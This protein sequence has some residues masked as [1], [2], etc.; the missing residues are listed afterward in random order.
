MSFHSANSDSFCWSF[1]V[2]D[3]N[4]AESN[5]IAK[6]ITD[7]YPDASV[8]M[9]HEPEQAL[10][11][12]E[13]KP[14]HAVVLDY[15][16][17]QID[18]LSLLATLVR[19]PAAPA[20]LMLTGHGDE[21]VAVA[22]IKRGAADYVAKKPDG[23]HLQMLQHRLK[24]M[25]A[26]QYAQD[27]PKA[28]SPFCDGVVGIGADGKVCFINAAAAQAMKINRSSHL[29]LPLV[30]FLS[31]IPS[32]VEQKFFQRV[33]GDLLLKKVPVV[34]RNDFFAN[35]ERVSDLNHQ[36]VTAMDDDLRNI[37]NDIEGVVPHALY[38]R[39]KGEEGVS[40]TVEVRLL[41]DLPL[42]KN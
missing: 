22:A 4:I 37:L 17:P 32:G 3:D 20:V 11:V 36:G 30:N 8:D 21:E 24:Q 27:E 40:A 10:D 26:G 14:V 41:D 25:L 2:I 35:G 31:C 18:G 23:S 39:V 28:T 42:A 16:M 38:A 7:I 12:L 29:G 13:R 15:L 5:L 33:Y 9:L 19:L 34:S 6:A 1:L